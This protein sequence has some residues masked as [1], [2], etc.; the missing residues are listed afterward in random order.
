MQKERVTV[1][2]KKAAGGFFRRQR[3]FYLLENI[4]LHTILKAG[5]LPIRI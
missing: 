2:K 3:H 5:I 1:N 4:P